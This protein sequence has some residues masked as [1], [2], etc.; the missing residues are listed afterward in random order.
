MRSCIAQRR[1]EVQQG[2]SGPKARPPALAVQHGYD[3]LLGKCSGVGASVVDVFNLMKSRPI[4]SASCRPYVAPEAGKCRRACAGPDG[5]AEDY[6]DS[7]ETLSYDFELFAS[8]TKTEAENV[9]AVKRALQDGPVYGSFELPYSTFSLVGRAATP[10]GQVPV[11]D[12]GIA[13]GDAMG[14]AMTVI[15]YGAT[16]AEPPVPYWIVQN[17]WGEKWGD[18]GVAYVSMGRRYMRAAAWPRPK[19]RLG[20]MHRLFVKDRVAFAAELAR[21][22]RRRK[23]DAQ[24]KRLA[25]ERA[26][27]LAKDRKTRSFAELVT[28]ARTVL[29]EL[30]AAL[31]V[32]PESVRGLTPAWRAASGVVDELHAALRPLESEQKTH[33]DRCAAFFSLFK[34]AGAVPRSRM[35]TAAEASMY[36]AAARDLAACE[37]L[38]GDA[39]WMLKMRTKDLVGGAA[40]LLVDPSD[41]GYVHALTQYFRADC[42]AAPDAKAGGY[43]TCGEATVGE[44]AWKRWV[45]ERDNRAGSSR[46]RDVATATRHA[47]HFFRASSPLAPDVGSGSFADAAAADPKLAADTCRW[48]ARACCIRHPRADRCSLIARTK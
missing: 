2:Y 14:H 42:T 22:E 44:R 43:A 6:R 5:K 20:A 46:H 38:V 23:S 17:Q 1:W 41:T 25:A 34:G 15:G 26:A 33:N 45:R 21:R 30:S 7:Y 10:G 40:W 28:G 24:A 27:A 9:E 3:C 11:F 37:M 47:A 16:N 8:G 48:L 31:Q 39:L 29:D 18:G 13:K 12:R 19:L 35:F 32:L 36:A 4:D